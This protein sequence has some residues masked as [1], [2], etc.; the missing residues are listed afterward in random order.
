MP[1]G[2]V[3]WNDFE[4]KDAARRQWPTAMTAQPS[5]ASSRSPICSSFL[6][7]EAIR[8]V[9]WITGDVH[10]AATHY[11][12][13]DKAA[14]TDFVPFYEFV[15]GPLCAAGSGPN[16][17]DR[18]F[19]PQVIFPAGPARR[20]LRARA[21]RRLLP[22]RPCQDRRQDR[23][24]DRHPSRCRRCSAAHHD[25][26]AGLEKQQRRPALLKPC[27]RS[28]GRSRG[29]ARDLRPSARSPSRAG[30]DAPAAPASG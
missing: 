2:L 5:A 21:V 12:D 10:Y 6:K 13:P 29:S 19:G 7:R 23:R 18:T 30:R 26:G 11:Y 28:P 17:L 9:H 14:F 3:V 8:N 24:H 15:S 22:L 25:V 1:L 16:E 20:P 4:R 27:R